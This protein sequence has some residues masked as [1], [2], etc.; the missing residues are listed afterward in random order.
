MAGH[1]LRRRNQLLDV[2]KYATLPAETS[3]DPID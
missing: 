3:A 1:K 2:I